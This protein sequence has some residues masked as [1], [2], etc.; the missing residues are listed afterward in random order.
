MWSTKGYSRA[1]ECPIKY[2][3]SVQRYV[4]LLRGR[5]GTVSKT[6]EIIGLKLDPFSILCHLVDSIYSLIA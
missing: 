1:S 6:V 5:F 4:I 3:H 2:D